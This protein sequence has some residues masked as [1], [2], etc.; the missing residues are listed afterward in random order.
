MKRIIDSIVNSLY[1]DECHNKEYSKIYKIHKYWAR[2]PWYIVEKYIL[3]YSSIGDI[4]MDPFCGSGCTGLEAI[5]NGRNFIGQDLNPVALQ[6]T[7]GT[8]LHDVDYTSLKFDLDRIEQE[9]KNIIMDLYQTEEKCPKCGCTKYFKYINIGPKFEGKYSASVFCDHCA[10][11]AEKRLLTINELLILKEFNK[12]QIDKWFPTIKFPDKFYKDRFSY[13]GI[14]TVADMY[15]RRNLYALSILLESIKRSRPENIDLLIL[16]FTN[17]VLHVSKLKGENVRPLG[18]NNYWVP[19]DYYEENVWFR[20]KDRSSNLLKAKIIQDERAKQKIKDGVLY[21]N[22]K[23]EKKSA[24]NSMGKECVDY[25]FTDPPYGEAIQY[26]ELSFIWNAW[27]N[28]F[29]ENNE[30]IIINPVQNKK[31]KEFLD[32]LNKSLN[33]IYVALKEKGYFT[34]CFQNKNSAIWQNVIEHCKSIGFK[35]IDVSIYDTYGSPFNKYWANFSPK[36]DIYVTFTKD[37]NYIPEFYDKKETISTII[38]E[39]YAYMKSNNLPDDNN[40]MYDLVISYLIWAMYL[41]KQKVNIDDFDI[42]KF[43]KLVEKAMITE[44]I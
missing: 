17:T 13:K 12:L 2:K 14:L 4:V 41:N 44:H 43:A 42:K 23:I 27:L 10:T 19:D 40:R 34:L 39:I 29:Y 22:Y 9:C 6:I 38:K 18:V 11:K 7:K 32:L 33:M 36:S 5:I 21:G 30:E 16:A 25:F 15:T 3:R 35:L 1:Q 20:F 28:A 8:L 31:S 37:K 26:S 24:L